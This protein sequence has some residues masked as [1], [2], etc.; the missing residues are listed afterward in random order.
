LRSFG[1]YVNTQY[2]STPVRFG[3]SQSLFGLNS[4]IT[5]FGFERDSKIKLTLPEKPD[6]L[7]ISAEEALQYTKLYNPV[8]V[9]RV[10]INTLTL[11]LNRRKEAQRNYLSILSNYW[12]CY[13]TIRKLTLFDFEKRESLSFQFERLL[14]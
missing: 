7:K 14:M 1:E 9:G 8:I 10:D 3:Y 13:Y 12:K 4:F 11:S 5:F 6:E 2:S